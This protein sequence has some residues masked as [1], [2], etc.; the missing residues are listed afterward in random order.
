MGGTELEKVF[1]RIV[2]TIVNQLRL[3]PL[4]HSELNLSL[5]MDFSLM[6]LGIP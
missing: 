1:M 4:L 3:E 6:A 2:V 5:S